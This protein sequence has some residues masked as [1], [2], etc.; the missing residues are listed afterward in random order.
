MYSL[1]SYTYNYTQAQ[2]FLIGRVSLF[3]EMDEWEFS[4]KILKLKEQMKKEED[5]EENM[6][7]TDFG[8]YFTQTKLVGY[9]IFYH[10]KIRYCII[11]RLYKIVFIN[12]LQ[13]YIR[14][15][16]RRRNPIAE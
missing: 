9:L 8:K 11:V 6:A 4:N 7:D 12:N 3:E 2:L 16:A 5:E 13:F 10:N 15:R 1:Y 14:G